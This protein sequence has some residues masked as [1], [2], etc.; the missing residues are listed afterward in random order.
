M[1]NA[2]YQTFA[3]AALA[4]DIRALKGTCGAALVIA[5]FA[6]PDGYVLHKPREYR[7]WPC[8][9]WSIT[10]VVWRHCGLRW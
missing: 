8:R 5:G 1:Q 6:G 3:G 10:R 9:V 4:A 7:R 2:R